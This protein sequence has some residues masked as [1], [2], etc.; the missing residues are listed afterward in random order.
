MKDELKLRSI[1]IEELNESGVEWHVPKFNVEDFNLFIGDNAQGKSRTLRILNFVTSLFTGSARQ[2]GTAFNASFS[3][4]R[5]QLSQIETITYELRIKPSTEGNLFEEKL[6]SANQVYLSTLDKVVFDEKANTKVTN[7]FVPK[8]SIALAAVNDDRFDTIASVR[9]FFQR[10]VL[11]EAGKATGLIIDE[12]ALRINSQGTNLS[13]VLRNW[14][15][16]YPE[17]LNE[18]QNE[19]KNCFSIVSNMNFQEAPLQGGLKAPV[20]SIQEKG[21]SKA[22]PQT[23]FSDG[24]FQTLLIISAANT[25]FVLRNRKLPPSLICIDEIENGLDYKTLRFV[26]EFLKDCSDDSQIMMTSHTPLIANFVHPQHW[27]VVKRSGP[28]VKFIAP[29]EVEKELDLQLKDYQN[30]YWEFYVKHIS[31][32][33]LYRVK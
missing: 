6:S 7:F 15:A 22:I 2:I 12:N 1:E 19:L 16:K 23:E 29:L 5:G 11:I 18:I 32:S 17:V 21:L 10:V 14:Q 28:K 25:P 24:V 30:T 9:E 31:N 4:S 20:L 3:F 27:K 26:T 33:P 13:S 8:N